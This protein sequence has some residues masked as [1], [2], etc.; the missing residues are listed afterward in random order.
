[1]EILWQPT[2]THSQVMTAEEAWLMVDMMKDVVRRGTGAGIWGSGFRHPAGGKTGTTND[3]NDV[4]FVGYTADLVAGVWMGYDRPRKIKA[5]AQGGTLAAP[6]WTAFMQEV[7]RRKP[8]PPDWPRPAG[9]VVREVDL[10]SGL[11]T[12]PY[13]GGGPVV[14]EFFVSGT[15]PTRECMP[16]VYTPYYD[17]TGGVPFDPAP[18]P[19]PVPPSDPGTRVQPGASPVPRPG[20]TRDTLP[21]A[22]RP[23]APEIRPTIP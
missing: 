14:T 20:Q 4:W 1:G 12:S 2:P 19:L 7:Y 10:R 15:E 18:R 9:I 13:C 8:A 23:A 21:G 6:A 3:G 5:N 11:L 22:R 16:A 17:T